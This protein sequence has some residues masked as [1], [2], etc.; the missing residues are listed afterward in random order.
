MGGQQR[1]TRHLGSPLT[2]AQDEVG[3]DREHGAACGAL[4]PP[5]GDPTETD[6]RI[7]GVTGEAPAAATGGLVEELKA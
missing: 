3:E 6:T 4:E 1:I 2:I 7:M 5:D